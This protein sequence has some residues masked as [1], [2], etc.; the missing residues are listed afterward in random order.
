VLGRSR[1]VAEPGAPTPVEEADDFSEVLVSFDLPGGQV[2]TVD[3]RLKH[4]P[5][6]YLSPG[7]DGARGL[8]LDTGTFSIIHG[9]GDDAREVDLALRVSEDGA[10]TGRVVERLR[11]WPALEWAEIVDRVGGDD[12]KMRQDFEQRWL[13]VHSPGARLSELS[14]E[15]LGSDGKPRPSL[16]R[17]RPYAAGEVRVR[18]AFASPRLGVAEAGRLRI[19][20]TFFRAQPGRRY[21]VESRRATAIMTS[22]EVPTTLVARLELPRDAQVAQ[23]P[24]TTPAPPLRTPYSYSEERQVTVS[25]SG[26]PVMTLR[27]ATRLPLMRV[28]PEAYPAFAEDLRRVDASER[29]DITVVLGARVSGTKP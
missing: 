17:P 7:L 16:S 2:V 10:A 26:A 3:P 12:T 1:F 6:G 13:G 22:F 29:E 27:R 19:S 14:V 21:A 20:P 8:A 18:Y 23:P 5:L 24:S 4:A 9:I 28:S 11:G 15:I 25:P